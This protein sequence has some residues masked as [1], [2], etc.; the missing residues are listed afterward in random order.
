MARRMLI[1]AIHPEECRVAIAEDDRLL[2]LEVERANSGQIRGNIYKS[3]ITRIEPS[4]QAAFLDIGAERNGFLQINDIHPS[5]F[6]NWPQENSNGRRFNRP[7][8]QDVLE[9]GQDLIVQVVKDGRD[10]K[11]ATLSTNLSLPGRYL[12]LMVGNQ[13]G[14]VSR[15]ISDESQRK[16]LRQS[17]DRLEIP[18]GMGVIVRTAGI[19]RSFNDLQRDLD[20]LLDLW[21]NIVVG[22]LEEHT[23]HLLYEESGLAIRT[24][25][26]YLTPDID[27]ILI[28]EPRIYEQVRS[29][30]SKLMPQAVESVRYYEE[31]QP[32]FAKF[33]LDDQVEATNQ[34]E[35]VLPSGGSIVIIPTEAVVT[36]D[37]NSGRATGQ[38]DVEETAFATNKEAAQEIA[39]QLRLRDLGGLVVIDFIDMWDKRH[40]QQVERTL[41]D[42]VRRDKAKIEMGR[43]SKFGLL[44][45]SRQRLKASLVSQ[46]Y[47]GCPH[48][49]GSGRVKTPDAAAL[50]ALRKLQSAVATGGVSEV[51]VRLAPPAALFLLNNKRST[52][53]QL[54]AATN[55]TILVYADGRM[56]L[57]D[58]ELELDGALKG[59]NVQTSERPA[60]SNDRSGGD[61]SDRR[62]KGRNDSR[63]SQSNRGS[64]GGG[65]GRRTRQSDD[66]SERSD[67]GDRRGGRRNNKGRR[68]GANS[69]NRR[70]SRK[71]SDN[72]KR[73]PRPNRQHAGE[74][75]NDSSN[76]ENRS[77]STESSVNDSQPIA[78]KTTAAPAVE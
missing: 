49:S 66:S 58:Y 70:S 41:K 5:Y 1:N 24:I 13:R 3:T 75:E 9:A 55:T 36:I 50:E 35:V 40:K 11:G 10:A 68:G 2:E 65:G 32:L 47:T 62:S 14:G 69:N 64:S 57:G 22:S 59:T 67:R 33:L 30:V 56:K 39:R 29:F 48:C 46:N 20:S 17:V 16:Q 21:R 71:N 38:A 27:E 28:D 19:N 25:R 77:A 42:A 54:E 44:E 12:V 45:M 15:K 53:A 31:R 7:S 37:V 18:P 23:P 61:R 72:N 78:P 60:R 52:L 4:L 26:D 76:T 51:R 43:I 74:S 34:P 63:R 73:G 8:I 6:N